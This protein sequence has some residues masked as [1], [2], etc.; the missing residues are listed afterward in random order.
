MQSC[1]HIWCF[2]KCSINTFISLPL[3][4]IMDMFQAPTFVPDGLSQIAEQS[5]NFGY[6]K[7]SKSAWVM[8]LIAYIL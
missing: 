5:L 4:L 6:P 3:D 7:S 1:K 2:L 8:A